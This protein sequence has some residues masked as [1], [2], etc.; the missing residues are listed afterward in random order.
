MEDLL[1]QAETEL[2]S[3]RR[4]AFFKQIMTKAADDLPEIY[5]GSVPRFFTFRDHVKG[6]TTDDAGR[7][8]SFEGGLTHTWL[9]K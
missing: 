8:R 1:K 3:N 4:K 2:D 6:F 5:I 7:F 9:E